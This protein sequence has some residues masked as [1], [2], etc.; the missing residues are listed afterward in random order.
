[1]R[2]AGIRPGSRQLYTCTSCKRTFEISDNAATAFMFVA[3]A[4]LSA[5]A[6]LV[7]VHPP[8]AAV[9]A[10]SENRWFGVGIGVFALAGWA[11]GIQMIRARVIH[12][13]I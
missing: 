1:M 10:E 3:A 4:L 8:G 7:I 2:S 6:W 13:A 9:G 12:P 11:L 5:V